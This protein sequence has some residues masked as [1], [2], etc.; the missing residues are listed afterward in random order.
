MGVLL[1]VGADSG[2]D[3]PLGTAVVI[4]S[5]GL[6]SDGFGKGVVAGCGDSRLVA[7]RKRRGCGLGDAEELRRR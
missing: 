7:G 2:S 1:L 6:A 3:A 5:R 4:E